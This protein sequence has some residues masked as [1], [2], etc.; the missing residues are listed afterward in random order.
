MTQ[1]YLIYM[2]HALPT[3]IMIFRYVSPPI[4]VYLNQVARICLCYG[5]Y[6]HV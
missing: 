1:C 2:N 4:L 6:T 5:T 3:S